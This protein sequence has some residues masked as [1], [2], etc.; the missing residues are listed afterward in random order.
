MRKASGWIIDPDRE[1]A[2]T[3]RLARK[4]AELGRDDPIA[5]STAGIGLAFVAGELEEGN[6]LIVA[7][8]ESG[9]AEVVRRPLGR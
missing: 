7:H 9:H 1:A 8:F 4:A 6:E 5:L 2:E 3:V